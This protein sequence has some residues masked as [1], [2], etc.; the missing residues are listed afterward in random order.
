MPASGFDY[1]DIAFESLGRAVILLDADLKV[2]RVGRSFER[3][4]CAG[5]G[6]IAIGRSVQ[7]MIFDYNPRTPINLSE[8]KKAGKVVEA[9]RSFLMCP[10]VGAIPVSLTI[11][12]LC[13]GDCDETELPEKP[14]YIA[15]IRPCEDAFDVTC[16]LDAGIRMVAESDSMK[17]IAGL[18]PKLVNSDSSILITGESGTG[19]EVLARAIHDGG[20][21]N[22]PFVAL[23][24]A[25]FPGE[26]L[27]NE[28]FGHARG[29]YTG[30][31]KA[32]PG[33]FEVASNGT[34]FLDEIGDMPLNLQVKLLRVLQERIFSR[35]GETAERK[36]NA[37]IIAA[38]NQDLDRAV[39]EGRFREDLYYRLNV[40][41]IKIPPLRE[42]MEDLEALA[43]HF[44]VKIGK[45]TGKALILSQDSINQLGRY[46]WPGNVRELE[47]ALEYAVTFC[48]GQFIQPEHLPTELANLKPEDPQP[49]F[50]RSRRLPKFVKA[51]LDLSIDLEVEMMERDL[52]LEKLKETQ[53]NK[54]QTAKELGMGRTTL[55]RKLN[56]YGLN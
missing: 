48:N 20:K 56:K 38:T 24:C 33:R 18:I 6:D 10:L 17:R 54:V 8:L 21:T 36:M 3:F 47:N 40:V 12:P 2:V 49:L 43:K 41:P 34:L 28:L 53:W 31:Y 52:I 42:R 39:K 55:Y 1:M 13:E 15:A 22:R 27:E 25:A 44:V 16:Q 19:K 4:V 26:L 5:A 46:E 7:D 11:A 37:R 14:R 9:K 30:A 23:N 35:L 50:S 32:Q 29:A 51:N 45:R